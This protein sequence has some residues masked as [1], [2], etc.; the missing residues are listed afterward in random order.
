MPTTATAEPEPDAVI[1]LTG[2]DLAIERDVATLEK[3]SSASGTQILLAMSYLVPCLLLG[4]SLVERKRRA[5]D[6]PLVRLRKSLESQR[7]R[8][9]AATA[10][11]GREQAREF[12][13]ALRG[14]LAAAPDARSPALESFLGECDA[15]VY[16]PGEAGA[17]FDE[18]LEELARSHAQ[19]IVERVK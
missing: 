2:A 11:S 12:A 9:D 5:V 6:P 3:G 8:I 10:L 4:L 14:M 17:K 19:N 15:L 7:R 16:A 1:A 13:A 18:P